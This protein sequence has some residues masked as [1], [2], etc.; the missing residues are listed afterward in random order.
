MNQ[1]FMPIYT[2]LVGTVIGLLVAW[3]RSL[4]DENKKKKDIENGLVDALRD[5][6]AIMLRKQLFEYYETYEHEEKIPVSEWDEI[7]ETHK[8]YKKLGGNHS[9]D[10]IYEEMKSKHLGG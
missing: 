3:I 7:E 9:G 6:M 8:V 10:R 1:Y 5:G 4:V 2:T